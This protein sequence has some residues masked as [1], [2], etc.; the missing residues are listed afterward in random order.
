MIDREVDF[1]R[2][3]Y[4]RCEKCGWKWKAS[5]EWLG[6]FFH[7]QEG[8]CP[9]CGAR[10]LEE[11]AYLRVDGDPKD[12]ARNVSKLTSLY[13]YHTSTHP[14]WPKKV[15]CP[16]EEW[17]P[18]FREIMKQEQ[19]DAG[20]VEEQRDVALH[21]GTYEAA[22]HNMIRRIGFECD[23]GKQFYLYRVV[24]NEAAVIA[25]DIP[26]DPA[27]A[28]G[29]LKFSSE[30]FPQ[31]AD[32][33]RYINLHED[34]GSLSLALRREAIRSVVRYKIP[35]WAGVAPSL[36]EEV[37]DQIEHAK[38]EP[39]PPKWKWEIADCLVIEGHDGPTP[40]EKV[41]NEVC[42]KLAK[43]FP[44]AICELGGAKA[45]R[46]LFNTEDVRG[47]LSKIFA[48]VSMINCSQA[49]MEE[50]NSGELVTVVHG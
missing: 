14:D 38:R 17:S 31:G 47:S 21:V 50:L 11:N 25:D 48:L 6:K 3:R 26:L 29:K 8:Q 15:Y 24:L 1:M 43:L 20:S 7:R 19:P 16:R 5:D 33:L 18:E 35:I 27:P 34:P 9:E 4:M 42:Q 49:V 22:V 46:A 12:A 13:W 45:I 37:A 36:V 39:L 2:S 44:Q 23:G 40:L 10:H 41:E 30:Y 28:F 32:I